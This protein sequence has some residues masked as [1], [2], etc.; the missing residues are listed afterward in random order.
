MRFLVIAE[1]PSVARILA[2][3]LSAYEEKDGYLEGPDCI[4]SWCVGHL[5]EYASPEMYSESYKTWRFED[6][7]IIPNEWMSIVSKATKEQFRILKELLHRKDLDYVVNACDAGR[8]GELIF[9]RVYDLAKS[10]LLVKRLWISS[11]ENEAIKDG[12][13]H[14][15]SG[16]EYQNLLD[17]ATCRAKA[18]WLVGMNGTRAFSTTYGT[19]FRVGRVQTPT[20]A[21]LVERQKAIEEFQKTP[22]YKVKLVADGVTFESEKMNGKEQAEEIATA[23][24]GRS[25]EIVGMKTEEKRKGAPK[26]YDLTT[27]QREA[28]RWYGYTAKETLDCLQELYEKQLLTYPRTDSC[29]VTS[30]MEDTVEEL[31]MNFMNQLLDFRYEPEVQKTVNSGK[32]TDHHAILPTK[33]A[34]HVKWE[35]LSK[36][37]ETLLKLVCMQLLKA[38]S[39]EQLYE[40]TM[41]DVSCGNQTFHS[42]GKCVKQ[43]GFTKIDEI[44]KRHAGLPK[45]KEKDILFPSDYEEGLILPNAVTEVVER[46][47]SPPKLFSEDTLLYAMETAGNQAF[48]KGTEKKGLGTPA[49]RASIIEKLVT[50][51]YA[52]RKGKQILPTEEGKNLIAILPEFV[53]SATMTAEWENHLLEMEHGEMQAEQFLSGIQEV[54]AEMLEYCSKVSEEEKRRFQK[55]KSIGICPVCGG[56]VY[57]GKTNYYCSNRECEFC[58]WKEPAYLKNMEKKLDVKSAEQL[59]EKGSVHLRD[60]YSRKKNKYF[61][62]DLHM[63]T[64]KNGKVNFSL[65]FPKKRS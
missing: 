20:L 7:P 62:A 47:T 8:E 15:K 63:E 65:S 33:Q 14:L 44:L 45:E 18:D 27:L 16:R 26:L 1:K 57:E 36:K 24:M 12:F 4:V 37:E 9:H 2:K 11:M 6:L 39:Q 10:S 64:E 21:M 34:M 49:T 29:Y 50:S 61:D 28:N 13:L 48:D 46:F 5:V 22:Y 32:V 58:L 59:L 30:D 56:T 51:S 3:N 35:N 31:A 40:E 23:C 43:M 54:I 42:K 53:K 17:A 19:S 38:V 60:L 55:K 41:L 25:V 52:T